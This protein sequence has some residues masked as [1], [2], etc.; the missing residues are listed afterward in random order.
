MPGRK[1]TATF[2]GEA[3]FE[4]SLK[5]IKTVSSTRIVALAKLAVKHAKHYKQLVH[6]VEKYLRKGS[7]AQRLPGLYVMDAIMKQSRAQFGDRDAFAG[8]FEKNVEESFSK[9]LDCNSGDRKSIE[10]VAKNWTVKGYFS[11]M[12]LKI[13]TQMLSEPASNYTSPGDAGESAGVRASTTP[14]ST[15]P[16]SAYRSLRVG[17]GSGGAF[18]PRGGKN[19]SFS[20]TSSS[21]SS[22]SSA[23]AAFPG[24]P[25]AQAQAQPAAA[26][27][28]A[29][30]SLNQNLNHLL[31]TVLGGQLAAP[32]TQALQVC[33]FEC[34]CVCLSIC[35]Y[36]Y[37]CVCLSICACV[38]M[39]AWVYLYAGGE[40]W[41]RQ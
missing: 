35:A 15:P 4:S 28:A 5:A 12:A 16:P 22:S 26:T 19:H 34:V 31:S 25:R 1:A 14:P 33:V 9:I 36:V 32:I 40:N 21:S 13:I 30:A 10:K 18:D 17:S 23:A 37:M 20:P 24:D 41:Q 38:C 27:A 39:C 11:P 8:R 7:R 3:E 6:L 29:T 2:E